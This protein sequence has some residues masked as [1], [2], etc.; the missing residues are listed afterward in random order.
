SPNFVKFLK[1]KIARSV[2]EFT[3]L[4]RSAHKIRATGVDA[5]VKAAFSDRQPALL[6]SSQPGRLDPNHSSKRGT[7]R[8]ELVLRLRFEI[9]GIVPRVQRARRLT[10]DGV[11]HPPAWD[12]GP[13]KELVGP[14]LNV[15]V[16]LYTEE[17][18]RAIEPA[19]RQPAIP[20]E[21]RHI[22]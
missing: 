6:A 16:L 9:A 17:L 4:L 15:L 3:T 11:D 12:G 20:G 5:D 19:F 14:T 1:Q 8:R 22:G 2:V 21:D 10:Q 18:P 7:C 13:L